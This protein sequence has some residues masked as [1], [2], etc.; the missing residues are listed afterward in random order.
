MGEIGIRAAIYR[1]LRAEVVYCKRIG[2]GASGRVYKIGLNREPFVM[3]V[4]IVAGVEFLEKEVFALRFIGDRADIG[5]PKVY[6]SHIADEEIPLNMIGMTY[7]DGVGAH[8]I[9]W[10]F[11]GRKKRDRFKREVVENVVRLR[12]VTNDKYGKVTDA[13]YDEW[14]DYYIPF[15]KARLEFL[16]TRRCEGRKAEYILNILEK[17]FSHID[18]ILSD[19]TLPTLIHG[20]YWLP[21]IVVNRKTK[22]FAGCVDP[23]NLMYADAEYEL[24]TLMQFPRLGL[25]DLY[26][27]TV[28]TS[29]YCDLKSRMYA[30][31]SEVYWCELLGHGVG[32]IYIVQMAKA[33]EKEL[34][35][36][37]GRVG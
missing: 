9:A 8:K 14:S 23:F 20:D 7:L 2:R 13:V 1:Y 37:G 29:R 31:F 26:K 22:E 5:L 6:F 24:F 28:P 4:K 3:A 19:S 32:R 10:P 34:D 27:Q 16:R 15:A 25:Y 12:S 33:L 35:K 30:L 17:A 21:N 36:F 11:V 18:T